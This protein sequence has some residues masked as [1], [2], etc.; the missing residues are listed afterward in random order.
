MSC[1][2]KQIVWYS[3]VYWYS[4]VVVAVGTSPVCQDWV[5]ASLGPPT[6]RQASKELLALEHRHSV[7]PLLVLAHAQIIFKVR[8]WCQ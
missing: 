8:P 3:C 7:T 2:L 1:G 4:P 5:A 6:P